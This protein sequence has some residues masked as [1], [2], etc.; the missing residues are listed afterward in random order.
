[1][2]KLSRACVNVLKCLYTDIYRNSQASFT[3]HIKY[4][5]KCICVCYKKKNSARTTKP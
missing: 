3:A 2:L 1:M 5:F 4:V